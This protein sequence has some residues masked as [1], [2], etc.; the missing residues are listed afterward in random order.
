MSHLNKP[1]Q[2][3]SNTF[4]RGDQWRFVFRSIPLRY[5]Q[6]PPLKRP[7]RDTSIRNRRSKVANG[8]VP[9]DRSSLAS[10]I[11]APADSSRYFLSWTMFSRRVNCLPAGTRHWRN[12]CR[13]LIARRVI[14]SQPGPRIE[15]RRSRRLTFDGLATTRISVLAPVKTPP[16]LLQEPEW[17]ATTELSTQTITKPKRAGMSHGC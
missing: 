11:I 16:Q 13:T 10:A 15:R 1:Q 6:G 8:N 4:T 7:R 14:A 12:R 3:S 9:G 5:L 17:L 2:R